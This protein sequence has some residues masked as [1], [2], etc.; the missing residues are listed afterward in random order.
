M[1]WSN[2]VQI[3]HPMC[4]AAE[5]RAKVQHSLWTLHHG[6][7]RLQ[8]P[9]PYTVRPLSAS[10]SAQNVATHTAN[11]VLTYA[12]FAVVSHQVALSEKLHD[13]MAEI[14]DG[15]SDQNNFLLAN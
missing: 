13:L 2:S 15:G 7:T 3:T 14:Q 6:H 4:G 8:D 12:S 1:R 11:P 10:A 9:D 5:T